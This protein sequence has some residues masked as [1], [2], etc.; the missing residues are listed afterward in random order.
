MRKSKALQS[1]V[2]ILLFLTILFMLSKVSFVITPII[3]MITNILAPLIIAGVLYYLLRPIVF[4]LTL[5]KIPRI[6]AILL[7]FSAFITGVTS[8]GTYLYPIV[9][10]QLA[11]F[12]NFLP[13]VA[14]D[15]T[16]N[17]QDLQTLPW[18][19]ELRARLA[20]NDLE[21]R[22]TEMLGEVATTLGNSTIQI[23]DFLR[24]TIIVIIT[25]PFVLFYMLKDGHKLPKT[26]SRFIPSA[27]YREVTYDVLKQ[28]SS[29]LSAYVQGQ[30]IVSLFVGIC[31]Y[32]L[33]LLLGLDYALI[34]ALIALF[35]NLIPFVGPFIGTVPGVIVGFI[36]E[37][38][39]AL[40]VIIGIIII[41]QIESNLISPQVMG[42]KLDVHP[43]TVILLLL[44]SGSFFGFVGLL[45]A[46]PTYCV[47]KVVV[48]KV[49]ELLFPYYNVHEE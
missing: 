42:K 24:N 41:Q 31:V 3:S 1:G 17:I 33:Y 8:V 30:V 26:F 29:T 16:D 10:H 13:N 49:Y 2:L 37:P 32:I 21:K 27:K 9:S 12:V 22:A 14:R 28:A 19:D 5:L 39:L 44:A 4:L 48:M 6:L 46:L 7:V 40:Y 25:V 20:N 43:V 11:Q 15:I 36:Q 38:R 23:I 34:L 47:L 35:T 18:S 45:L